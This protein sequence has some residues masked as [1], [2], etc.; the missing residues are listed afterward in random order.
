LNESRRGQSHRFVAAFLFQAASIVVDL[1]V[2]HERHPHV[3]P[4]ARDVAGF[5]ADLLLLDPCALNVF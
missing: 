3:D 1:I 4:V 2:Q 5:D